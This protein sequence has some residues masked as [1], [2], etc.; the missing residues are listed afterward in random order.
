MNSNLHS[1]FRVW[2]GVED[3][4]KCKIIILTNLTEKKVEIVKST[5]NMFNQINTNKC[6]Y[7]INNNINKLNK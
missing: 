7:D 4:Q 1:H 3:K 5:D 2:F 6:K